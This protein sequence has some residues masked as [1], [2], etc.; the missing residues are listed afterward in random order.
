MANKTKR[1]EPSHP[2]YE[3]HKNELSEGR[4]QRLLS[5]FSDYAGCRAVVHEEGDRISAVHN[6]TGA[7]HDELRGKIKRISLCRT[8]RGNDSSHLRPPGEVYK[9]AGAPS[10]LK[11]LS[12]VRVC[13]LQQINRKG[14]GE[15]RKESSWLVEEPFGLQGLWELTLEECEYFAEY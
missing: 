1:R 13:N 12:P 2:F 5:L 6:D 3:A 11:K 8:A 14:W 4:Y 7:F 10:I 9:T 15:T